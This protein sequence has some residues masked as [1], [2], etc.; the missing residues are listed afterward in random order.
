M[1]AQNAAFA[2]AKGFPGSQLLV[3]FKPNAPKSL[4]S[5]LNEPVCVKIAPFPG[6]KIL[7]PKPAQSVDVLTVPTVEVGMVAESESSVIDEAPVLTISMAPASNVPLPVKT[8]VVPPGEIEPKDIP[9]PNPMG[10]KGLGR[11]LSA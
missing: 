2:V 10:K 4:V 7:E 6:A 9:K 8:C 3:L 11:R 1:E 5:K